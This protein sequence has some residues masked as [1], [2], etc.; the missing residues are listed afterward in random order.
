MVITDGKLYTMIRN[1]EDY[2]KPELA[3]FDLATGQKRTIDIT[4][5]QD[6]ATYH[7]GMLLV[8]VYDLENA[9]KEGSNEPAKPNLS[10]YNPADGS[11][12]D[13]GAFGDAN[14]YG[15]AYDQGTDTLFYATNSKLMA[16]KALG[17]ATQAAYMP[18]DYADEC[19]AIMLTGGLYAI[20]T[21]NGL[22]V[23]NTDP[24]YMP[25]GTLSIYSGYMDNAAM[26]FSLK[27]SQ[28]PVIF[29]QNV[30]FNDEESLAQSMVSADNSFDI[31]N[32]DISYQD[33]QSLMNKGYCVDLSAS[34]TLQSELTKI[35]P[36]LQNAIQKD[37]KFY[38]LPI[39]MYGYGLSI[40]PKVWEDNG[41]KDKMP[42]SFLGLIDFMNWWAEEGAAQYP[43]VQLM[44]GVS[45]Y[46]ETMFQMA[47]DLYVHQYQAQN[48]ELTFDTPLFR[49][50]MDALKG[51]ET[52]DLNEL[53]KNDD[54]I[55]AKPATR[56]GVI[57]MK[58]AGGSGMGDALFM[59]YGD[60]VNVGYSGLQNSQ[61]LMLPLEDGGP[62]ILPVYV[63]VMFINPNTKN[64]DMALK[65]LENELDNLDPAQHV[66]MFPDDNE[67]V[68]Q[69]NFDKTLEQWNDELAK[70]KKQL[71]TA[72]PEETKDIQTLIEY[73]EDLIAKKDLYYWQVS[74]EGIEQYRK[75][76]PL[77][78]VAVPNV[79]NYQTKEGTSE[80]MTLVD[81][82]RQ[83]QMNLDQFIAEVDKKIH[84]ILQERK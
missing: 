68:P 76:A 57:A 3:C 23:R 43:N 27:Y 7:D 83:K 44:Q 14:V 72:K 41:L 84:M 71:E 17:P 52:K 78:Y 25:T 50:M 69:P 58:R 79:L 21:W 65:Y 18:I 64:L 15:M 63:Q 35:Y 24:Q 30:Y 59:N 66:M 74:A 51:L 31:Y 10:I 61:P 6:I 36:F 81:R 45:D 80:V 16:M 32:F 47:M 77:C 26:S 8:K 67:P 62:V 29:N 33:F 73:Y 1:N 49:E 48:Q 22:I 60:W 28:T 9:Y 55:G 12:K 53:L 56:A 82:Y 38:A 37:G 42:K 54:I 20:D 19:P 75:V 4:F 11:V 39:S 70:A 46:G 34:P 40:A 2:N 5:A 13:A